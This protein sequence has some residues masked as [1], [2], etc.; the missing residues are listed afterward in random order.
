MQP[1]VD[2]ADALRRGYNLYKDNISTLLIATLLA[3]I[4]SVLTIGILAGPMLA[5]LVM[6][7]LGLIDRQQPAP[8]IGDL[9]KGFSF[10]LPALVLII[11]FFVVSLVG[12]FI[13]GLIPILGILLSTLFSMALS[14]VVMF[15]IFYIVDRKQEVVAAIQTSYETVKQNFWI[16]LGLNIVA[17]IVSSL[18]LIACFIGI[19]VTAPMY[20]CTI[21]VV[22]RDL[23]PAASQSA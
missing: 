22:Y 15:A 18:G 14:T 7:T 1:N 21:A 2:I 6:L 3:T 4:I 23:H 16:F 10:F 13:L 17:S 9:F 8:T 20:Y 5:G 11:L 19:I 12:Q